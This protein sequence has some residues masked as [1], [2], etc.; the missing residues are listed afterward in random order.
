VIVALLKLRRHDVSMAL[1]VEDPA[2][3]LGRR[4]DAPGLEALHRLGAWG[5]GRG[6]LLET[7]T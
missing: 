1:T 3:R 6:R 2:L 7:A 5:L 4:V